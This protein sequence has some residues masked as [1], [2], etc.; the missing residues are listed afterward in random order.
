LTADYIL[1]AVEH[2]NRPDSD[3]Q[4]DQNR[5][6]SEVLDFFKIQTT[7]KI[8]EINAGRGY[9][10]SIMAYALRQGGL[11]Y[12]HTSPMSVERW[13][14]NPIEKRLSEFPQD[15]LISVVGE[16]ESPNFPEKLDKIFN[17]MTYHDSVWTKADRSAMNRS[18]FDALITGGIYG[19]L[20][21][22]AKSGHGINDCH[23]IHRIEKNF[24]IKEV[25]A[26]GF[27][28]EE[29]LNSLE[30]HDDSLTSMVFEKEIRDRTSRFVLKFRK[31]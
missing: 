1:T 26:S 28:L 4:R 17:V 10:S 13:K 15:N 22:H 24:V 6:P 12:A 21:H 3:R 20:D 19:I 9:F 23:S 31:P 2:E 8:G 14:G 30:N 29:E 25:E 18:I 5:K 11:V 7:D 16:M 27:I